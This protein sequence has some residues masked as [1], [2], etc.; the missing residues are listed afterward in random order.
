MKTPATT[1]TPL[2][3]THLPYKLNASKS[4]LFCKREKRRFRINRENAFV[5]A[6]ALLEPAMA[7]KTPEVQSNMLL[8]EATLLMKKS[9]LSRIDRRTQPAFT[10][11]T[12]R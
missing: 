8:K 5:K 9:V 7:G 12:A 10:A 6:S 4:K 1:L 2:N 3:H 11:P